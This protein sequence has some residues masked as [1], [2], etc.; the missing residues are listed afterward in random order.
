[1]IGVGVDICTHVLYVCGPKRALWHHLI[2]PLIMVSRT[3]NGSIL[4]KS[5][6]TAR[7]LN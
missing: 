3:L 6:V 7:W 1:M 5:M 4:Q 2:G